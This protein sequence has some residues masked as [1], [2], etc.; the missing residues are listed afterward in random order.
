M[1]LKITTDSKGFT[2]ARDISLPETAPAYRCTYDR[3]QLEQSLKKDG[4]KLVSIADDRQQ[5]A[6]WFDE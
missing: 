4:F 3:D 5:T 2:S 1:R 6:I